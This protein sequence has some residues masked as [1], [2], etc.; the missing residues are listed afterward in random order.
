[1]TNVKATISGLTM[2]D[3]GRY[4]IEWGHVGL[5]V[6]QGEVKG[7]KMPFVYQNLESTSWTHVKRSEGSKLVSS[8]ASGL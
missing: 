1:M 7:L 3:G 6:G 2:P 4:N 5:E 8:W